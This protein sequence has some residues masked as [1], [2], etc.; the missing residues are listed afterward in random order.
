MLSGVW[1]W[2]ERPV[3]SRRHLWLR[4]II[5]VRCCS[6]AEAGAETEEVQRWEEQ[7]TKNEKR[8]AFIPAQRK[9]E[10]QRGSDITVILLI[11][12]LW[13]S[14][15]R[16]QIC[17][18][19]CFVW[20][21][22]SDTVYE[23]KESRCTDRFQISFTP[24]SLSLCHTRF[25]S[26]ILTPCAGLVI[27]HYARSH[28][29]NWAMQ[30]GVMY[31]RGGEAQWPASLSISPNPLATVNTYLPHLYLDFTNVDVSEHNCCYPVSWGP[32]ISSCS[33]EDWQCAIGHAVD[34]NLFFQQFLQIFTFVILL[35]YSC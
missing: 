23:R 9:Q 22:G 16:E 4:L 15:T 24:L 34:P 10:Q 13:M 14:K 35:N 27:S 32:R 17:S 12:C 3:F 2:S 30:S 29:G 28:L 19:Q 1:A 26:C 5:L 25:S 31:A 33:Y 21:K 7:K 20:H 8:R 18:P 11:S 6:G